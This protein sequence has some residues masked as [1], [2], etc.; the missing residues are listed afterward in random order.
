MLTEPSIVE[1]SAGTN[2]IRITKSSSD[3]VHIDYLSIGRMICD[4]A[5]QDLAFEVDLSAARP[6]QDISL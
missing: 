5:V 3:L 6:Q 1:L 2:V 4:P